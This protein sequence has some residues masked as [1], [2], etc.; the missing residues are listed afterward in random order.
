M[1]GTSGTEEAMS[2]RDMDSTP[3]AMPASMSPLWMAAATE[4]NACR[5]EE[6]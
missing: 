3:P 6:H 2:V 5:P 1:T 4:M